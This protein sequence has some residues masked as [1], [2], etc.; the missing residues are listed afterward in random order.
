MDADAAE[1]FHHLVVARIRD[2]DGRRGIRVAPGIDVDPP[3]DPVV[4]EDDD[5]DRQIVAADRFDF[6]PGEAE[7]AVAFDREHGFAGFHRGRDGEA[8]ADAHDAPGADV[9]AF[10]RLVHVDDA[11]REI[12]R[13]GALVDEDGVRPFF[14]D[15]AQRTERAV[16]IHRCRVLHQLRSHLGRVGFFARFDGV[17]P[18]GRRGLPALV[19]APE[20]G[21]HA[22]ADVAD[23]R[24]GDLDVAVHLLGLDVDLDELLRS[25]CTPGLALAVRQEPVEAGADQQHDVG[26]L[27]GRRARRAR[28]LRVRVGQE[29]FGHAH[30]HVRDAGLLDQG[31]DV[32]V[33][34]RVGRALAE[35]DQG[36]LGALPGLRVQNLGKK[37]GRQIEIDAARAAGDGRAD[38]ARHADADVRG[39]QDAE[40]RFAQGPGDGQLVHLLVIALLQVDDLALGRAADQDH[41]EAVGGGVR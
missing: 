30:R 4:V 10:A 29:A 17:G 37:F 8:H 9:E 22:G 6:H 33:G 13:V 1:R 2:E 35:D 28:R 19:D 12:E 39:M 16:E 15:G 25:G 38:R 27:Q 3:V 21:G 5:A 40:G 34:L 24:G 26:L 41:R 14:D 20:E 31:A 23:Q 36:A 32:P 18:I 11:A 7:G